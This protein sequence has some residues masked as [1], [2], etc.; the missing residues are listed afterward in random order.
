MM[1]RRPHEDFANAFKIMP[2]VLITLFVCKPR[3][4]KKKSIMVSTLKSVVS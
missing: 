4:E 1:L 3:R 2:V